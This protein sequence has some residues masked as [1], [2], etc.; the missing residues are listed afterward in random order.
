[1]GDNYARSIYLRNFT[2]SSAPALP[3]QKGFTTAQYD[4]PDYG[5]AKSGKLQNAAYA[6]YS[7]NFGNGD[8]VDENGQFLLQ[9]DEIVT[10]ND[11]FRRGSYIALKELDRHR[12]CTSTSWTVYEN[13]VPVTKVKGNTGRCCR[14]AVL[15]RCKT[16]MAPP[17]TMTERKRWLI[18]TLTEINIHKRVHRRPKSRRTPTRW[19]FALTATRLTRTS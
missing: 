15:T 17:R 19:F 12:T 3:E 10:F 1:M 2:F 18:K 9:A 14:R 5:S 6:V 13:G 11:Q 16:S 8:V 4:V 7:S